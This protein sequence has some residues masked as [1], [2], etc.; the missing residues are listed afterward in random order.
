MALL[1]SFI[2]ETAT[3]PTFPECLNPLLA[4]LGFVHGVILLKSCLCAEGRA[5]GSLCD[6]K[7]CG[8]G[9][10]RARGMVHLSP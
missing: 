2:R 8:K 1:L 5:E 9:A 7:D 3:F 6:G 10:C 4:Q